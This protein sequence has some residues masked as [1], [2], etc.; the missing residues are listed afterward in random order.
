M[1][2]KPDPKVDLDQV[3]GYRSSG[4]AMVTQATI[5]FILQ[6]KSKGFK[7]GFKKKLKRI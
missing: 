5:F 2:Y 7:T 1:V 4:L 3:S 6:K